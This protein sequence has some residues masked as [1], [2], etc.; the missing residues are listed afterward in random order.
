M[1]DVLTKEHVRKC[2]LLVSQVLKRYAPDLSNGTVAAV[3]YEAFRDVTR[4]EFDKTCKM[5]VD[6]E[7]VFPTIAHF[8]RYMKQDFLSDEEK[9]QQIASLI[10]VAIGRFGYYR[11]DEARR[12]LGEAA[13]CVVNKSGG[14]H[15]VCE[16]DYDR[17]M[18][19]RK[20]WRELASVEVKLAFLLNPVDRTIRIEAPQKG[21]GNLAYEI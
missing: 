16:I 5:I 7:E 6:T 19:E 15:V 2:L 17:I 9:G 10:E 13:W 21:Y 8:K 20:R 3:Y 12:F 18:S 11:P 1:E 14:W 4:K